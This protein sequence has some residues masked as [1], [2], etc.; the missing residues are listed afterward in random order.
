[1]WNS[2]AY[3]DIGIDLG[4]ATVIANDSRRNM[5]ISEPALVAINRKTEK[6]LAI[7]QAVYQMVGRTPEY[8]EVLRP[9][10]EGVI[11]D[12]KMTEVLIKH[13]LRRI[14]SNQLVKPRVTLC[15]PSGI[16]GVESQAVIDAAVAAGARNVYLIEEPVAAAIGAGIN[17]S[18]PNGNM[19]VDIGGGTT[20]IAVLSLNGIVCK[21]SLRVAGQEFDNAL[22]KHMRGQYNLLVGEKIAEAAKI[23][24]GSVDPD[25][26]DSDKVVDVKGRDLLSGLPKKI[27]V[28]RLELYPVFCEIADTIIRAVQGVMEQTPPELV[29]DIHTNGII[30]TGGGALLH[31]LDRALQKNIKVPVRVAPN[32]V[33]CVAIGTAKSFDYLDTLF[34]GFVQ[35]STHSH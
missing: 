26:S 15:V 25:C 33:E 5:V 8:I 20:D 22:I 6:V 34:D 13:L 9:L 12:Y 24:I 14:C 31:G 32:A 1:M 17:L 19:I 28:R 10:Q 7:G 21:T 18:L 23:E 35:S 27:P 2:L 4:T 29:G 16:T 3:L 11:S 30:L